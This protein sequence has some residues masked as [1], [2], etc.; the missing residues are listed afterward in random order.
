MLAG[1]TYAN[2]SYITGDNTLVNTHEKR[3]RILPG[4]GINK[5]SSA[6]NA[7]AFKLTILIYIHDKF[8]LYDSNNLGSSLIIPT[9]L[10]RSPPRLADLIQVKQLIEKF[11]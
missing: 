4:R 6:R 1:V 3:S 11:N 5:K 2:F 8:K 7:H 10:F 9:A